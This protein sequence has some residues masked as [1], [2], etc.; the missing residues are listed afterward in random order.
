MKPKRNPQESCFRNP[1]EGSEL[2]PLPE[3]AK[4][5]AMPYSPTLLISQFHFTA[6]FQEGSNVFTPPSSSA[7]LL[8]S[9]FNDVYLK[10]STILGLIMVVVT[11]FILSSLLLGELCICCCA[12]FKCTGA[13]PPKWLTFPHLLLA[14]TSSGLA[15]GCFFQLKALSQGVSNTSTALEGLARG[16]SVVKDQLASVAAPL[17]ALGP[18]AA[19]FSAQ[20]AS[21]SSLCSTFSVLFSACLSAM[22]PLQQ[23][24]AA[25]LNISTPVTVSTAAAVAVFSSSIASLNNAVASVPWTTIQTMLAQAGTALAAIT[26]VVCVVHGVTALC[27]QS[28]IP[29]VI[30]KALSPIGILLS[31]CLFIMSAA[32][33]VLALVSSDFCFAPGDA[34]QMA[35]LGPGSP[36][37]LGGA[38]LAFVLHCASSPSFPTNGTVVGVIQGAVSSL[39]AV[40][41]PITTAINAIPPNIKLSALPPSFAALESALT[42]SSTGLSTVFASLTCDAATKLID[43]VLKGV[44]LDTVDALDQLA[45][46]L[47]AMACLVSLQFALAACVCPCTFKKGGGTNLKTLVWKKNPVLDKV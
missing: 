25:A 44:C 43:P 30:F 42:D 1:Q 7:N 28:L 31:I 17:T 29:G 11:A 15:F 16:L 38:T 14:I 22:A 33:Y 47:I 8:T 20:V 37:D 18:S 4:H 19:T 34:M 39:Q 45:R 6:R 32:V 3:A 40:K 23:V 10:G 13:S 27:A 24:T 36:T 2:I 9:A 35:I 5:T 41:G 26:V 46:L 21:P 12:R